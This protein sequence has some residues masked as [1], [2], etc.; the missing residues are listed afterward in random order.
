MAKL[1]QERSNQNAW[2]GQISSE[3]RGTDSTVAHFMKS[4]PVDVP[5]HFTKVLLNGYLSE[6]PNLAN[7]WIF[8]R[9]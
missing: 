8:G 6:A 7:L 3:E 4:V 1:A 9:Y 2:E 5:R